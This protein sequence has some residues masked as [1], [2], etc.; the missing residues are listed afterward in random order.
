MEPGFFSALASISP[1]WWVAFAIALGAVEMLTMSFF[2]IWPALAALLTALVVALV[3]DLSGEMVLTI[4]ALSALALTFVGRALVARFGT[5]R[6]ESPALNERSGQMVG[7]RARVIACDGAEGHVEI[8][9][10]RWRAVWDDAGG[11]Q[12]GETV[13]VTAASGMTLTV[14][15]LPA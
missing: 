9:G 7:R 2:L 3:P 5:G 11:S 14:S 6:S 1:W 4:F 10:I 13:Q 15:A 8:D 12:P